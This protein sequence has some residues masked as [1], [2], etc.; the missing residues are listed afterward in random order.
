MQTAFFRMSM[1]QY[2]FSRTRTAT[3]FQVYLVPNHVSYQLNIL[4]PL[5]DNMDDEYASE[6]TKLAV[7]RACV[8]LGFKQCENSA[9]ESLAD[10]LQN[11]IR[12]LGLN[13]QEQAEIS[14]RAHAGIQDVIPVL[15]FTVSSASNITSLTAQL[16]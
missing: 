15:E 1:K 5:A 2:E 13:A 8:A 4:F 6:I 7:A 10:I 12:T 3:E 9:I 14:G 16:L 11:Y